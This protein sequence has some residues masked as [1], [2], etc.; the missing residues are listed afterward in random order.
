[1]IFKDDPIT[2]SL[3]SRWDDL[4][5]W[6]I[7]AF[8][9]AVNFGVALVSLTKLLLLVTLFGQ[10]WRDGW[11]G[12]RD[13]FR[14][15]PVTVWVVF[16]ALVWFALTALWT[17]ADSGDALVAYIKHARFVWLFVVLYLIRTTDRA[18]TLLLWLGV[19]QFLML[20][21]SWMLWL[22]IPIPFTKAD[23]PPELGIVS[24]S[25]LE[26]PIMIT[27]FCALL[28]HLREHWKLFL[29]P[30]LGC[31]IIGLGLILGVANV[32]F[33]MTGRTGYLVMFCFLSLSFLIALPKRWRLVAIVLSFILM[34]AVFYVSPRFNERVLA[35][36]DD[37]TKF[38]QGIVFTSQG[39]RLDFWRTSI[40]GALEKPLIGHGTGSFSNVYASH[41]GFLTTVV[42]NP[43]QQYLLWFVE[44]GGIALALL[45]SFFAALI[46]DARKLSRGAEL[47]LV[48]V[49]TIAVITSLANSPFFDAGIGHFFLLVM[50]GLLGTRSLQTLHRT[51][52]TQ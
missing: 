4:T 52:S 48:S 16:T 42:K 1:M 6:V 12:V 10:F 41:G 46:R 18:W 21:T 29:G 35:V 14:Q 2:Y 50:A 27:L 25:T 20:L 47:A 3:R 5:L 30:R 32:F 44:G 9:L 23:Y 17:E 19:G 49:T 45:I 39:L 34:M 38:Q 40:R 51:D 37:V 11:M 36:R 7:C 24:S 13:R 28:W 43:H 26:Q 31:W 8:A 22:G 33:V 15:L